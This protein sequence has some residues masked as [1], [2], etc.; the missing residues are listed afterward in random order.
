M[1]DLLI[2]GIPVDAEVSI[3]RFDLMPPAKAG[4]N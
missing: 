4:D 3:E 1:A 2:L